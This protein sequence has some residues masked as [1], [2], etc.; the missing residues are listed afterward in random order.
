MQVVNTYPIKQP[1]YQSVNSYRVKNEGQASQGPQTYIHIIQRLEEDLS[2]APDVQEKLRIQNEL[3][4][5]VVEFDPRRALEL[6]K[7]TRDLAYQHSDSRQLAASLVVLGT[8]HLQLHHVRDASLLLK[9]AQTR[10][11]QIGD[12]LGTTRA[13]LG[14]GKLTYETGDSEKAIHILQQV[15]KALTPL[16]SPLDEISTLTSL[17]QIY[18]D[19]G[20]HL[21]DAL[22]SNLQAL[23]L[24]QQHHCQVRKAMI[25]AHLGEQYIRI[26]DYEHARSYLL[27]GLEIVESEPAP[28]INLQE[29]YA[30]TLS[31]LSS[32]ALAAGTY[33]KALQYA[34]RSLEV[35]SAH[36]QSCVRAITQNNLGE[37]YQHLNNN[38]HALDHFQQA[39]DISRSIR[40]SLGEARG[41]LGLG[42]VFLSQH[43]FEK[44]SSFLNQALQISQTGPFQE[45]LYQ[46]YE[47]LAE[48]YRQTGDL[49]AAFDHQK[50]SQQI[51]ES[52]FNAQSDLRLKTLEV[53]H[54]VENA[55]KE[56][57]LQKQQNLILKQEIE[58]R[59]AAET[60]AQQRASELEALRETI[61]D[62]T[63]V[64]DLSKLLEKIVQR[65][66]SLFQA[67]SGELALY[68]EDAQELQTLV[69]QNRE[70]N[71]LRTPLQSKGMG[72]AVQL[73][74]S[75]IV[76]DFS[77]WEHRDTTFEP[78]M[79]LSVL[80]TPLFIGE[81]LLGVIAVAAE[82]SKRIFTEDD[83]H[84]LEMFAQQAAV[85]IQN[86][87]LFE[88]IQELANTDELTGAQSRRSLIENAEKELNR[89]KR[90]HKPLSI[91]LFEVDHF[92]NI[93]DTYGHA[94]GDQILKII[95]E[96][97]RKCTRKVDI[98]GRYSGI[99]FMILQPETNLNDA[100]ITAQRIHKEI[101]QVLIQTARGELN[102]TA[103]IGV[104]ELTNGS[105]TVEAM[106]K[107]V[108]Q[109]MYRAR[110][111]GRNCIS[112]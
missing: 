31:A 45:T 55:Q 62:I 107:E 56:M 92:K 99:E 58:E 90:Y 97:S 47:A 98:L 81:K 34:L 9:E 94:V 75:F 10:F 51:K 73:R 112:L 63:S 23:D 65:V 8:A 111:A 6:G 14:L 106:F 96:I 74:R 48:F 41:S 79:P 33:Q 3:A 21:P 91:L 95:C 77:V 85:A 105:D 69:S 26:G 20:D 64:L 39:L 44:S 52:V 80:F 38:E 25:L 102:I 27:K 4:W 49:A 67:N 89:C 13:L 42:K 43:E 104:S 84:L 100:L 78:L 88:K 82:K 16:N 37:I 59:K 18:S 7:E 71:G 15:R 83:I 46:T 5:A 53:M 29:A 93:N 2:S 35:E 1:F 11:Q 108:D 54:K 110:Q 76:D 32:T 36:N 28:F 101:E 60:A 12:R 86:A 22:Q 19:L 87:R 103:S 50:H 30:Y 72:Y 17:A 68:D 70:H 66:I 24:A 40:F 57:E 109:A 61:T